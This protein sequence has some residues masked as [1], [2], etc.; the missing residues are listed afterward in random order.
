MGAYAP[1]KVLRNADLERLVDTSDEWIVARTGIR[2]RHIV[3]EGQ[4]TSDLAI[5]AGRQALARAGLDVA[6]LELILVATATPDQITPSTASRVQHGLGAGRAAGFDLNAACAG[7]VHALMSAHHLIAAGAFANA[8]VLGA[9]AL[10]TLTDYQERESCVLF[11][12]GAGALVLGC[13]VGEGQLLDHM[14][15]LDGSRADLIA[16]QAGG[17]RRP[18]SHATVA[19]GEHYLRMRGSE[20]FRFAVTKVCELVQAMSARHGLRLGEIGLLVPH[21][22]NGRIL[23]AVTRTLGLDPRRVMVNVER[24][25]NTSNASIPLALEE[26]G[27]TGMVQPGSYVLLVAFGG[28]LS[29]G[30]S[31]LRW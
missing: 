31:L 29:W 24:Y 11:G 20:V 25:G 28:G 8:L 7:F 17:S 22:A 12:D 14:V 19:R 23:E 27:R 5:A 4:A 13:G 3:A 10:S 30:A 1:E 16:V 26:A 21:Q 15:G 18:A 9:D 6:D 2:E